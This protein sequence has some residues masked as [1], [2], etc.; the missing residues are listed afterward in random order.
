MQHIETTHQR[1]TTGLSTGVLSNREFYFLIEKFCLEQKKDAT[2]H[3]H[4]L[5]RYFN[6][7]GYV[8]LWRIPNLMLDVIQQNTK[9]Q[10]HM[11]EAEFRATFQIFVADLY[12]FCLHAIPAFS[13]IQKED[14]PAAVSLQQLKEQQQ[15]VQSLM[16]TFIQVLEQLGAEGQSED[17]A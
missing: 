15:F 1:P 11:A 10:A 2:S 13:T 12:H 14:A 4:F 6:D 9:F 8:D 7:E 5:N 17:A 16:E 3:D